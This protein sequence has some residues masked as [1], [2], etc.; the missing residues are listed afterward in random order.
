MVDV[1]YDIAFQLYPYA[2]VAAQRLPAQRHPVVVVGGGPVGMALALDLG[3][4]GTPVLV[5]DDHEGVG[6]GSRAICFAK[7]TLEIAN[8]LGAGQ[9]M[10][11]KGIVWNVGKVF[12]GDDRVFQFNL[13]PEDGHRCPAFINLQQPYFEKFLVEEIRA[14][15][16]EGAPIEIRGRNAVTATKQYRDHV[17]LDVDTPDGPYQIEAEWLIACDGARSPIRDMM[18]LSFDGRVFEDNFLIADVKMTADFPT[19]RWFWFEPPFKDAGQSALLH[20]QPDDIWRIDFQLGWDIDRDKELKEKNVRARVDAMLGDGAEYELEWTSIY[21]FQCRRMNKF[22]H[23]RVIFAGDSAHQVSP[24]GARGA[25]SGI[26]DADNLAWKLDLVLRNLAPETLLHTYSEERVHGA[27]ENILNSTRATDFLTPKS[28]MSKTFRNAILELAKVHSFARPMVN[29]GRLSVPC[30]YDGLSLNGPDLLDGP[31]RTRVG[32]PCVDAPL[33]QGFL[34][35]QLTGGFTLLAINTEAPVLSDVDGILVTMLE[36]TTDAADPSGALRERYLGAEDSA[37]YLI[38]PDQH[39]AA[40]W[41]VADAVTVSD[42]F[43]TAVGKGA[44][45]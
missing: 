28:E 12:H 11:D 7:R 42:A 14:A 39:V 24:F 15:Q 8:R 9:R 21:T 26:Q 16:A 43:R 18:G 34:L 33:A 5:L 35:D 23:D 1:R 3:R 19:E 30:V 45:A 29:S 22:R 31:D 20:K 38:R 6:Q 2:P 37:V 36:L 27:D 32:A 40:R 13:Q 17:L 41:P 10:I 4:K 25:N 44:C